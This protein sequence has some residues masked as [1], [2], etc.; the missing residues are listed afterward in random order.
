MPL[1][2]HSRRRPIE[3]SI[4]HDAKPAGPP[5]GTYGGRDIPHS[6]VDESGRLYVYAGVAPRRSNGQFDDDALKPGEFIVLPELVYCLKKRSKHQ[7][8]LAAILGIR[9]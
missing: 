7:Q 1:V 6:V 8:N 9:N 2:S 5:I 4:L 3:Y